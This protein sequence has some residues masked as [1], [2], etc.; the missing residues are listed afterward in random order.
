MGLDRSDA[1]FFDIARHYGREHAAQIRRQS[2]TRQVARQGELRD[3]VVS[4]REG[5]LVAAV[6]DHAPI[7]IGRVAMLVAMGQHVPD[8]CLLDIR[9][10]V[11]ITDHD[12]IA[13][14]DLCAQY[15][16]DELIQR[17][18]VVSTFRRPGQHHR[19]G[20]GG[21]VGM[22]KQAQQIEDF[23]SRAHS[24][25]KHHYAVGQAHKCLQALFHV[26]HD[27]QCIDDGIGRL[28]GDDAGL[29]DADV[30]AV[31]D[32]LLGMSNSR[33]LH[34]PLHRAWSAAG[35]DIQGA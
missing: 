26:R 16:A 35:A 8:L 15:E 7:E 1:R 2:V 17:G 24:A 25:R 21:V 11:G 12:A 4:R 33:T 29:G 6:D 20:L 18:E 31:A 14:G 32:T 28:G 34:R 5:C 22:S 10:R 13:R 3:V 27:D 23:L 9:H 30:A 19:Q